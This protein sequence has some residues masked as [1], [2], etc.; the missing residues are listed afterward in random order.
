MELAPA[1]DVETGN[2]RLVAA[3]SSGAQASSDD[4]QALRRADAPW[5]K[6]FVEDSELH[7]LGFALM[8]NRAMKVGGGEFDRV[9]DA[10][11]FE[12]L[13]KPILGQISELT[14]KV[15]DDSSVGL[16]SLAYISAKEGSLW[17]FTKFMLVLVAQIGL[18]GALLAYYV[19]SSYSAHG[20]SAVC[21]GGATAPMRV[22]MGCVAFI[23][24]IKLYLSFQDS[25]RRL[26]ERVA[27]IVDVS[28][29]VDAL[30]V[31]IQSAASR[32]RHRHVHTWKNIDKDGTPILKMD[33]RRSK[34]TVQRGL[35]VIAYFKTLLQGGSP[36]IVPIYFDV[37]M[38]DGERPT[39]SD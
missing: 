20:H 8:K 10:M 34:D 17:G 1:K 14:E 24:W 13:P 4:E 19:G 38:D 7:S 27:R 2:V 36:F 18:F 33:V 12:G 29:G 30:Q 22:I 23:Y 35:V 15:I 28:K 39:R 21:P 9:T 32:G 3:D 5:V 37:F 6:E 16:A 31:N 26:E 11:G 25:F